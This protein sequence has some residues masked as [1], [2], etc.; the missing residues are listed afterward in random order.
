MTFQILFIVCLC[1]IV[2]LC[3]SF[4]LN[5]RHL[6]K[7]KIYTEESVYKKNLENEKYYLELNELDSQVLKE[8]NE[9]LEREES[10]CVLFLIFDIHYLLHYLKFRS[11]RIQDNIVDGAQMVLPKELTFLT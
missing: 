7:S 8:K 5:L 9:Q 1:L 3:S 10:K 6:R 2:R 11:A 4:Y